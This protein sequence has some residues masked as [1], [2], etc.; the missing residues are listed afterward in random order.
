MIGNY[1]YL[2]SITREDINNYKEQKHY[3]FYEIVD[4]STI[5]YLYNFPDDS[6]IFNRFFKGKDFSNEDPT[7]ENYRFFKTYKHFNGDLN[8]TGLL[9][10]YNSDGYVI[11]KFTRF[12]DGTNFIRSY[13]ED[14]R[15]WSPWKVQWFEYY[16][17]MCKVIGEPA[18]MKK[19]EVAAITSQYIKPFDDK[20]LRDR[21]ATKMD[22]PTYDD[23]VW[24]D[25]PD[26]INRICTFWEL[27]TP[28]V[29]VEARN[30]DAGILLET[31]HDGRSTGVIWLFRMDAN[32]GN[33]QLTIGS[34]DRAE[35]L[36]R[37]HSNS[38][39]NDKGDRRTPF[40]YFNSHGNP[41]CNMYPI[42]MERDL[43][44]FVWSGNG[45]IDIGGNGRWTDG[46]EGHIHV[47]NSSFS[48]VSEDLNG[49]W[50]VN[51][52][53]DGITKLF[54][55]MQGLD[56]NILRDKWFV[57]TVNGNPQNRFKFEHSYYLN[58]NNF[59]GDLRMYGNNRNQYQAQPVTHIGSTNRRDGW[60]S[61]WTVYMHG[62]RI[63]NNGNHWMT[64]SMRGVV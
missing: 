62:T 46:L 15:I 6:N 42:L 36:L 57:H 27:L 21:I 63:W 16:N 11:Q 30:S 26:T 2:G 7:S 17:E 34:F 51:G 29:N 18:V 37:W 12:P 32:P 52:E 24:N 31:K 14:T 33:P 55:F 49:R 56:A 1:G 39:L 41:Y 54:F 28:H 59:T 64:V 4:P 45:S 50:N 61:Q 20:Y 10:V 47:H 5:S 35:N 58:G 25:R 43:D 23:L 9:E 38:D 53:D 44:F 22:R 3:G 48:F 60:H 40:F 13:D 8:C 19:S